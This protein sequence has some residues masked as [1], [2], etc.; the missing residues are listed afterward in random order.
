MNN[1]KQLL[2]DSWSDPNLFIRLCKNQEFIS[3]LQEQTSFL[4]THYTK[5][6]NKHR[7]YVLL[8]DITTPIDFC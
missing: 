6:R 4:D 2:E 1:F 8:N 7:V 3:T 5:V